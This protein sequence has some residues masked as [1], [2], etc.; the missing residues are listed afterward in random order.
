MAGAL[1]ATRA[2]RCISNQSVAIPG[3]VWER[4]HKRNIIIHRRLFSTASI[5][6]L[7]E[8]HKRIRCLVPKTTFA[9]LDP[10]QVFTN[11]ELRLTD[12]EVIG[13]DYDYTLAPYN[14]ALEGTIFN[15]IIEGLVSSRH[16]PPEISQL[17]YNPDFLARGV[18]FDILTGVFMKVDAYHRI[19]PDSVYQCFRKLT[20]KE[21]QDMYPG[22]RLFFPGG[23]SKR[24]RQIV[25]LF[26]I[27]E[28]YAWCSVLDY[29]QSTQST[30]HP[31][32]VYEDIKNVTSELHVH[33]TLH[34]HIMRNIEEYIEPNPKLVDM[35]VML[36]RENKQL[37]IL[38]NSPYEFLN[39]GMKHIMGENWR[40]SFDVVICQSMK[41]K[42]FEDKYRVFRRLTSHN[43][44][45]YGQVTEF[46][47]GEVYCEGNVRDLHRLTGWQPCNILYFGDQMYADLAEPVLNQGWHTGAIIRELEKEI[48][49]LNSAEHQHNMFILKEL[50]N[51]IREVQRFLP[52]PT[53]VHY[54]DLWCIERKQVR[55]EL[56]RLH[57][58]E[59][60]SSFRTHLM[61]TLFYRRLSRFAEIYTS[62]LT[63][64]AHYHPS[65]Y[66]FTPVRQDLPH[67]ISGNS[68]MLD[69]D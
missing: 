46:K 20:E 12:I 17:N 64:L 42:F 29:L 44:P 31:V 33:G 30:P 56:R 49:L 15:M 43:T 47:E 40:K 9:Q 19:A 65:H 8:H 21:I 5:N 54:T 24:F 39:V 37:F 16:Y 14:G 27:P 1:I 50:N 66:R 53:A 59:F 41:P 23:D 62:N 25:D 13:F 26:Q 7:I 36:R 55:A 48:E 69:N 68:G 57:I 67:E 6:N 52:D 28:L 38:T 4:A 45:A 61:P 10:S 3:C 32:L 2:L 11:S 22:M 58:S 60:C 18:H 35:L 34:S 63:N 51:L